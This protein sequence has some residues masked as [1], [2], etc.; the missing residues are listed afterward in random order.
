MKQT[1]IIKSIFLGGLLV[2]SS[3]TNAQEGGPG[4][5]VTD[6]PD[7]TE[8]PT[9]VPKGYIQIETGGFYV[10]DEDDN[11]FKTTSLGYNTT[12]LRY[13][14]LDNLELRL[15]WDNV[16]TEFEANGQE[17]DNTLNGFSTMLL[18]VKV[19]IT[20][21]IGWL[22]EIGLLGH[23]NLPFL[24]GQD[25]RPE[26][27]GADFRFSFAHTLS[28]KSSFSYNLGAKWGDDSPEIA[29]LY[30]LVYGLSLSDSIG[31]YAELYG[32]FPEDSSA[33]HLWDAGFTYL[34]QPNLQFD[35]TVGTGFNTDQKFLLSGGVSYR[36]PN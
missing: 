9:L 29:Y 25:Y 13:G 22:P 11:D 16:Q 21:E 14:L 33:N 24:A 2:I 17:L 8:S 31:F 34:A 10:E 23:L 3:M 19:G 36:F 32:D 6:R 30:T 35:L 5:I 20:E 1:S 18:G 27:T 28:E 15:G 26:T 12:L 7:Q 4:D